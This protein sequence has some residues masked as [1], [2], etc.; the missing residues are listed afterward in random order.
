MGGHPDSLRRHCRGQASGR[1]SKAVERPEASKFG[2]VQTNSFKK[3]ASPT[4]Y[5]MASITTLT[6][7]AYGTPVSV[8]RAYQ[9]SKSFETRRGGRS[10][11][12]F[13][14][15]FVATSANFE[16]ARPKSLY[17]NGHTRRGFSQE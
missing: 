2:K 6:S 13:A 8:K 15:R 16:G 4:I 10:F 9:V 11:A 17:N 12:T 5:R 3:N 1:F 7:V 14:D